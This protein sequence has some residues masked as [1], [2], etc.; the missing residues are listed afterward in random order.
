MTHNIR[1]HKTKV[2]KSNIR[3]FTGGNGDPLVIIHGGGDGARSWLENAEQLAKY[4]SVYIPDLPGFG[5]SQPISD[6]FHL[7][8]YVSFVDDF[9]SSLGIERFYLVGH[10]IGGGIALHYAFKHSE[11]IS[12]L[13]LVNSFCLGKEIALWVRVLSASVLCRSLGVAALTSIKAFKLLARLFYAPFKFANP[14][15]RI[16]IDMGRT[17]TTLKG[18]TAVLQDQLAELN[19]PTLV[20]WGAKDIIVPASHAYAAAEVI[21]DCQLHIFQDCGHSAYKQRTVEFSQVVARFLGRNRQT[22]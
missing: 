20:V 11:K 6:T 2:G 21:P 14:L 13:V 5:A 3:Y 9:T 19:V 4:Y 16:K 8:D 15:S 17:M 18:Q 12:G 10:S 1:Q 7:P 22:S